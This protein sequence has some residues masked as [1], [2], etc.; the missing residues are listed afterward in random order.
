AAAEVNRNTRTVIVSS[1]GQRFGLRVDAVVGLERFKTGE[2][3]SAPAIFGGGR[4]GPERYMVGVGR[5]VDSDATDRIVVFLD[6][7][8]ALSFHQGLAA[9]PAP[10]PPR[11]AG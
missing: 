4:S 8:P 2:I 5:S 1:D 3:E 9:H 6:P 11:R 10:R 7:P